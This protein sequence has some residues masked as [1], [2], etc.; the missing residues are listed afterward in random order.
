MQIIPLIDQPSQTVYITLNNQICQIDIFVKSTGTY[1]NVTVAATILISGVICQ[2]LNHIV[3]DSY[4]GFI[5][6]L[7][8]LD[9][10]GLNDPTYPGL[11]S[12]YQL[13]YLAPG[14]Y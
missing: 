10:Q 7:C 6:D 1:C 4:L 3:R 8:F 13:V 5:G 2:N 9:T 12:R 14:D 11:G